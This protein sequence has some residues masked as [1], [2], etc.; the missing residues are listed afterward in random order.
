[1]GFI[2]ATNYGKKVNS[3]EGCKIEYFLN[4]NLGFT[5]ATFGEDTMEIFGPEE[6]L[7]R[8]LAKDLCTTCGA[9][10]DLCPYFT[11]HNAKLARLFS[12]DRSQGRCYAHC[13]KI[14]V[15]FERLSS[16]YYDKPYKEKALGD[17]RKIV[18]ARKGA[19]SPEGNFQDGGTV[20]ALI[21]LAMDLG[22][23][24]GALL[25]GRKGIMPDPRIVSDPA[26]VLSCSSSKY[27]A[28]PTVSLINSAA[29]QGYEKLGM[30][31][32]PCQMTALAQ[33]RSNPLDRED[34]KDVTRLTLG[35]FCTW[36]VDTHSFMAYLKS[37]EINIQEIQSMEIPPPPAETFILTLKDKTVQFPLNEVRS[38]V[39]KGC[40]IC[41][42]MT[43]EWS[44]LSIGAL[45]GKTGWNTLII[46]SQKGET[47]VDEAVKAGFLE[48]DELP[49]KNLENLTTACRNKKL[50]AKENSRELGFMDP[51]L[52]NPAE[53]VKKETIMGFR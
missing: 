44:D 34:F 38:L 24:D 19:K 17:Y 12:C 20:S 28:S 6:L 52:N 13:P 18:A 33:I 30:V 3:K 9:C 23:I 31:G 11:V 32:T 25:T 47:L 7:Q 43:S 21:I 36:A 37:K 45:E 40:S 22:W 35:L 16:L 4:Y 8:V 51:K 29:E 5:Q 27:M 26:G 46:R 2:Y 39:P 49:A 42:D 14:G 48:V 53:P 10:A 15:D 50:R 1:M 41:P